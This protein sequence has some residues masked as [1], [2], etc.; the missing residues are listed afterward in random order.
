MSS[1]AVREESP[2]RGLS[3]KQVATVERL[4]DA[5]HQELRDVGFDD[6]TVRSTAS[7][8][9]VAPATAYTYFGSKNHLVAETF[10]RRL[11]AEPRST[12]PPDASTTERVVAVMREMTDFLSRETDLA[13]AAT[14]ALLGSHPDVQVLRE[15]LGREYLDRFR[16]ALDDDTRPAVLEALGLAFSGAMLQAGMG[17]MSYDDMGDRLAD[18]IEVI[19]GGGR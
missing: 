3:A 2:R 8:A 12:P 4:T 14:P 17:F 10:W 6:L 18:V 13:A 11:M 19:L 9:R 5:A 15:R 16:Q 1:S 7:R